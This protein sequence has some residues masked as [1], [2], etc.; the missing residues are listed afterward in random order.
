MTTTDTEYVTAVLDAIRADVKNGTIPE[1]DTFSE[2]HDHTDANQYLLDADIPLV[3][4]DLD[5]DTL[6]RVCDL[7]DSAIRDGA[8][9]G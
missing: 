7:V 5:M 9:A 3:G 4:D 1:V 8:L 2:L 6:N